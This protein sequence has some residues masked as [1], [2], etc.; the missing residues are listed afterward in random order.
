MAKKQG[1]KPKYTK[2]LAETGLVQIQGWARK[3]LSDEQIAHNMGI[4]ASTLYA[5][6]NKYSEITEALKKGKEVIDFEVENALL[7]SALGYEYEESETIVTVSPNGTKTQKGVKTVK[8]RPPDVAA[9]IFWLKNRMPDTWRNNPT[10]SLDME[11]E[12]KQEKIRQLEL[13]NQ[14]LQE[15]LNT[16]IGGAKRTSINIYQMTNPED[17][18]DDGKEAG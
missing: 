7:K 10:F 5:W 2:W 1:R 6:Q 3:G 8:Y 12:E 11:I 13:Q 18:K 4:H 15:S 9:Q 17:K 16:K 14:L